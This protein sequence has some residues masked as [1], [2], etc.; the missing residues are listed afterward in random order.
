MISYLLP[1]LIC[2]VNTTASVII[3]MI[4]FR[5]P[6]KFNKYI[7]G[8]LVTRYFV[9]L[10]ILW[11]CLQYLDIDKFIFALIFIIATFIGIMIEILYFHFRINFLNLNK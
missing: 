2:L 1:V 11:M 7:F 9:V 6:D 4:A 5:K 8:S 10:V 3:G